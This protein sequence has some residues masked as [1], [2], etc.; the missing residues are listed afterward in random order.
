[1]SPTLFVSELHVLTL[2]PPT[3]QTFAV[4]CEHYFIIRGTR[5][6]Q[7]NL[8]TLSAPESKPNSIYSEDADC[9]HARWRS[10]RGRISHR[11]GLGL[12][13]KHVFVGRKEDENNTVHTTTFPAC[14]PRRGS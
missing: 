3:W 11:N 4:R 6:G 1:M 5:S 2:L 7:L 9:T 13:R 12:L 8:D 10:E 14:I